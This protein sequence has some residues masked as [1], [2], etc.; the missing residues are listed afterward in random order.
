ME[1]GRS[2]F[3]ALRCLGRVDGASVGI[4]GAGAA[5]TAAAAA[6]LARRADARVLLADLDRAKCLAQVLDL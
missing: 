3:E 6:L 2:T 4:V 1:E 5:G